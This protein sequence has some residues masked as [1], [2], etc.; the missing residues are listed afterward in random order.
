MAFRAF[1]VTADP[2]VFVVVIDGVRDL[3]VRGGAQDDFGQPV[4]A[5][6]IFPHL[7]TLKKEG[8]YL[9][10]MRITN[11]K[12]VSLP[13]YA[14]IFAGRRQEQITG[15]DFDEPSPYPTFFQVIKEKAGLSATDVALFSSWNKLCVLSSSKDAG[16]AGDFFRSC[17][18]VKGKFY[19]PE[20]FE[21]SRSDSDTMVEML[22]VI[23]KTHPRL[24]FIHLGDADEEAH[25]H[26]KIESKA[27][28]YYGIYS[29]HAALRN[30]DYIVGRLWKLLQEDPYYKG[31][32]YL[33]VTTDHG[34][35]DGKV[36]PGWADHGN[37]LFCD[38]YKKIFGVVVGP[39]VGPQVVATNY[40]HKDIAPT[41]A[42][43]FNV[44]MPTA[45]G[46]P[47]AE[48][49]ANRSLTSKK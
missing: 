30:S 38:G 40:E 37:C 45:E 34:R 3:E 20:I 23:P 32:T 21:E 5:E 35:D 49:F 47:I 39:G 14:D 10:E 24:A 17:G 7:T 28:V 29:Y 8:L 44:E 31:S 41:L 36:N 2:K 1:A 42:K 9:P 15:N 13:G 46:K 11:S 22:Q 18:W 43:I 27:K 48:V 26:K 16:S 6:S 12:G 4:S 19:K 25:L 33:M